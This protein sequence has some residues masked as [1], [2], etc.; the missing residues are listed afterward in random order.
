VNAPADAFQRVLAAL[1]DEA[2]REALPP[3]LLTLARAAPDLDLSPFCLQLIGR[4]ADTIGL[5]EADDDDA[6]HEKLARYCERPRL[7]A[8]FASL[9]PAL[10]EALAAGEDGANA[11]I[12]FIAGAADKIPVARPPSPFARSKPQKR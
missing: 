3:I 8:L 7:Q 5:S 1:D 11:A 4:F 9:A 6:F 12:G 2:L 10:R